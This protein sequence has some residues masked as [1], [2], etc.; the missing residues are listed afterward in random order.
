MSIDAPDQGRRPQQRSSRPAV[1]VVNY[2]SSALLARNLTA[3]TSPG[4]LVVVVDNWSDEAER[5]AVRQL[6]DE[7]GWVV[8]CPASNTGFGTGMNLGVASALE[9]GATSVVLLNPDARIEP[10]ATVRL[11]RQVEDDRSLLLAPRIVTS[12]GTPWMSGLMDLRLADG[13]MRSS[14]HRTPGA[15]VMEWVSGAVMALSSDLWLRVGGFDDDYF[16][17]WEDVDLCRRVHEA[18]GSVRVDASVT[19][20]H[21][22]GGTHADGGGRAKSETFYYYNI[23]NR[24]LFARKWLPPADRRRW[25]ATTLR[26][27]WDTMLTGGRRQFVQGV[28]P[29]RAFGRGVLAAYRI[30]GRPDSGSASPGRA[31]VTGM[32]ASPASE[33]RV[34]ESFRTPSRL[35]NPY[36]TQLRD[37]L[38]DTPGVRVHCWDWTFA[39]LGGYDVFHTHWTEALIEGRNPLSTFGRRVLFALFLLRLWVTRTPVVRTVHNLELPSGL[40]AVEV[41][42]LKATDRLTRARVVLNEFTPVPPGGARVLVPHGHYRDWYARYTEPAAVP[43]R[44]AFIGKVR[45]YKNV[46]G[47]ARAFSALPDDGPAY[48]LH[49]AGKP[50]SPELAHTLEEFAAADPRIALSL[51][52]VEDEDLVREVGEAELVVLPYHEMHNSGSVLAVLSLDRPVLVP[53]NEFNDRLAAE[54]GPGWVVTFAGELDAAAIAEALRTVRAGARA[55]RPD[56]GEREW[57]DAGTL[58]LAAFREA[59]ARAHGGGRRAAADGP[60]TAGLPA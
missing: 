54:V 44:I 57:S 16:L 53:D 49:I 7:H 39:L 8:E 15:A 3:S 2:R 24:A 23:R 9:R 29:W 10:A 12:D 41:L 25:T 52:F 42:L 17:Y 28:A 59:L 48:S 43:N 14:R 56:L 38:V 19:A 50:S 37:A 6:G 27:A 5:R 35:T 11:V 34:L 47:L 31:M 60:D 58:H 1:V 45:R 33:I 20:V 51:G 22:E 13:T 36:I 18:G 32:P 30:S 40:S 55:E 26:A 21:D 46:E 4:D